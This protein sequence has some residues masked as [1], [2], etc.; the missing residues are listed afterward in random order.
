MS[1]LDFDL[2]SQMSYLEIEWRSVCE[3]SVLARA[4]YRILTAS[5]KASANLINLARERVDRTEALK[6]RILAKI[7]RLEN[8]LLDKD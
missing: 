6:A 5:T 8:N 3:S 1:S 7:E 4:D 2:D